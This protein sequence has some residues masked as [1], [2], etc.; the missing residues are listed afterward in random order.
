[1]SEASKPDPKAGGGKARKTM[2]YPAL[3]EAAAPGLPQRDFLKSRDRDLNLDDRV[4]SR[5]FQQGDSEANADK[6]GFYCKD[7]DM[8]FK[9]SLSYVSHING[10]KHQKMKGV[11]MRVERVGADAFR[12]K[13]RQMKE[14]KDKSE[15][16]KMLDLKSRV[17]K[18]IA[19]QERQ[20]L[21]A[22]QA[23]KESKKRRRDEEGDKLDEDD[24]M[25]RVMG[26]ASFK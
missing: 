21:E 13:L 16:A 14:E 5:T 4:G 7:C 15:E 23:R 25:M 9:D 6:S 26:F 12:N 24:E 17:A 18:R 3:R 2:D 22:K 1:M 11:S 10:K 20:E 19:D 8:N